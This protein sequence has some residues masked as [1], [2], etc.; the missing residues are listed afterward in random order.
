MPWL[1]LLE[2]QLT[3]ILMS[4]SHLPSKNRNHA[5]DAAQV[6]STDNINIFDDHGTFRGEH[7]KCQ[8]LAIMRSR[9]N[10]ETSSLMIACLAPENNV[11]DHYVAEIR[12]KSDLRS[13]YGIV[14]VSRT[15]SSLIFS[16]AVCVWRRYV[17]FDFRASS[18]CL[19]TTSSY[20]P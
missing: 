17:Y 8:T 12:S 3:S 11:N 9:R 18:F 6:A 2:N 20:V 10:S 4:S 1:R 19:F 7:S 16:Y 5:H 13:A 14:L 15:K